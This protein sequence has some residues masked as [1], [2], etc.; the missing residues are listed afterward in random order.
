MCDYNYTF[1][2]FSGNGSWIMEDTQVTITG[3]VPRFCAIYK[4]YSG[5]EY[6]Q[7][8]GL[9]EVI[10]RQEDWSKLERKD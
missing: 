8:N 3:E 1:D 10:T 9:K 2:V 6:N 7:V 4:Y 5:L